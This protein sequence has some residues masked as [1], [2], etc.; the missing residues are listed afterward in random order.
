MHISDLLWVQHKGRQPNKYKSCGEPQKKKA[1]HAIQNV[2]NTTNHE[3]EEVIANQRNQSN[4]KGKGVVK[5]AI[6]LVI[7]LYDVQ[8]FNN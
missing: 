4:K 5:N 3:E 2:T 7:M 1:K 8:M 6:K